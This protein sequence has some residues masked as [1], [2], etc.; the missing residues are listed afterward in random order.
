MYQLGKYIILNN[1][2]ASLFL[3]MALAVSG[4]L[5]FGNNTQANI[6]KNYAQNDFFVNFARLFLLI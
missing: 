5:T 4:Y 3:S 2:S 1:Y 6:L